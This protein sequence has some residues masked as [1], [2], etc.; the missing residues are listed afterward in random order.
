M[1]EGKED[2]EYLGLEAGMRDLRYSVDN[3]VF[4]AVK[5]ALPE[6]LGAVAAVAHAL[7]VSFRA[8]MQAQNKL[9][10]M[11]AATG[12]GLN[13]HTQALNIQGVTF[14]KAVAAAADTF[15][16]GLRTNVKSSAVLIGQLKVLDLDTKAAAQFLA[17]NTQ[18]LG[19]NARQSQAT[20]KG[21]VE[22]AAAYRISGDA[23]ISAMRA[24]R[25]TLESA[26]A[27]YG[28]K[29]ATAI[30]QA[31]TELQGRVGQGSQGALESVINQLAAGTEESNKLLLRLG[32]PLEMFASQDPKEITRGV[33][34]AMQTVKSITGGVRGGA[35]AGI[36]KDAI[37]KGWG[38][39]DS[40]IL[41]ADKLADP[42]HK[43]DEKSLKE[44]NMLALQNDLSQNLSLILTPLKESALKMLN[45][46]AEFTAKVVGF[47]GP[48]VKYLGQA[49]L[50]LTAMKGLS[51]LTLA[52]LTVD[53]FMQKF[54]GPG[55]NFIGPVLPLR[56]RIKN[57][58]T[59]FIKSLAPEGGMAGLRAK[60]AK[61]AFARMLGQRFA[62]GALGG[63]IGIGI[64]LA[65]PMIL[66]GL[67]SLFGSKSERDRKEDEA[68][69]ERK[70]TADALSNK[71]PQ[72]IQLQS[73]AANMR[74][75]NAVW[76]EINNRSAED[77]AKSHELLAN[78]HDIQGDNNTFGMPV[79]E[80]K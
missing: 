12:R 20:L 29:V 23:M 55:K 33:E 1:A 71:S 32:V 57:T 40:F 7:E 58:G 13:Q 49:V 27:A 52:A 30:T 34:M 44:L 18:L 37:A 36:M 26:S 50:V 4:K 54:K 77:N 31:T 2:R 38:I 42:L 9:A 5:S 65:L 74:Q 21:A 79:S 10:S 28:P 56:H 62:F 80:N 35:A 53:K 16:A 72:L 61:S 43:L 67:T 17:H 73:I 6:K 3:L 78:L 70:R 66:G 48:I 41:L 76:N 24:L 68:Q 11:M 59:N 51:V 45:V 19:V 75:A 60:G 64:S 63:P 46:A 15:T 22:T 47:L 14:E 8:G 69:E 25:K 39:N